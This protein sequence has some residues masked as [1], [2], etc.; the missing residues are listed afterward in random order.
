VTTV[1]WAMGHAFD[2]SL[3]KLPVLDR[4]G[5]PIQVRGVTRFP[6]LA[7]VGM[8]WMPSRRTGI[9]LGMGDTARHVVSTI[10]RTTAPRRLQPEAVQD[11]P[12]LIAGI[13]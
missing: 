9:H 12:A 5:F 13:T 3:V 4:D 8:P 6:G 11:E 7:F 2:F 10:V 1:I